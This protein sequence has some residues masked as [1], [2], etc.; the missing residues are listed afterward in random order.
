MKHSAHRVK[1]CWKSSW[2]FGRISLPSS[3]D[4]K[5]LQIPKCFNMNMMKFYRCW[6]CLDIGTS[7]WA[8]DHHW[9]VFCSDGDIPKAN[10]H[11]HG[12]IKK[13]REE[14]LKYPVSQLRTDTHVKHAWC[15]KHPHVHEHYMKYMQAHI[16]L[17]IHIDGNSRWHQRTWRAKFWAF[18]PTSRVFFRKLRFPR[19]RHVTP[20]YYTGHRVTW[21]Q[22][23]VAV[24]RLAGGCDDLDNIPTD[25]REQIAH[26]ARLLSSLV[27]HVWH[28]S[29]THASPL[30]FFFRNMCTCTD[31]KETN[32]TF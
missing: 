24:C 17:Y 29:T 15:Q 22:L 19:R 31:Y 4:G 20:G 28:I 21:Q 1:L 12:L 18:D 10:D 6:D 16:K 26:A 11:D 14:L 23:S 27:W 9:L 25:T 32:A 7:S 30:C 5:S 2:I 3:G 13:A 8:F